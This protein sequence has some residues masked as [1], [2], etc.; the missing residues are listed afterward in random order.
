MTSRLTYILQNYC[1]FNSSHLST[2]SQTV[3]DFQKTLTG[4]NHEKDD[5][6]FIDANRRPFT[7]PSDWGF[8]PCPAFYDTVGVN[9]PLAVNLNL[10]HLPFAQPHIS[11]EPEPKVYLQNKLA[12]SQNKLS[13]VK[14]IHT[15]KGVL[16][17]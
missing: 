10:S 5:E 12:R 16:R 4:V 14:V 9:S 3:G 8:E 2:L 11:V 15:S 7:I 17:V 13:E 1:A 6:V